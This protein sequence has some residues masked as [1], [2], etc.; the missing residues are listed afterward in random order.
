MRD[1]V[2]LHTIAELLLPSSSCPLLFL[3][4]DPL[5]DFLWI[6]GDVRGGDVRG[7]DVRGG[8]LRGEKRNTM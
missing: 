6:G 5:G 8:D 7:G 1:K 2:C 4:L 3:F